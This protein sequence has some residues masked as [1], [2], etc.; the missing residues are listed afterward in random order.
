[1]QEW[2]RDSVHTTTVWRAEAYVRVINS[3]NN[4]EGAIQD[5]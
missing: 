5:I 1:M 4:F 2:E 3:P